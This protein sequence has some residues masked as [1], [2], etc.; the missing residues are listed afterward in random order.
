MG[1]SITTEMIKTSYE[2]AR[3]VHHRQIELKKALDE[4]VHI[5]G[6]G[7]G[8]ALAYVHAFCCMMDGREYTRTINESAT[9]YFLN[10]IKNDYS[11]DVLISACNAAKLHVEYYF[12]IRG[13]RLSGIEKIVDRYLPV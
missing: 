1:K 13:G 9:D 3:K 10:G 12:N 5:S 7:K 4:I 6:M 8:S 11:R 2:Y